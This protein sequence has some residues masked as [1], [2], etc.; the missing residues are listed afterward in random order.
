MALHKVPDNNDIKPSSERNFGFIFC[1]FF[2]IVALWPLT[3]GDKVRWWA[4]IIAALF[5]ATGFA[6]PALLRPLNILWFRFGLLLHAIFSPLILGLIFLAVVV[7]TGL[8]LRLLGKDILDL[9]EKPRGERSS[10]WI[11][12][13][14]VASYA[15]SMRNQF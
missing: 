1:C 4:L 6:L 12:R 7:P 2:L 8:L 3:L 15:E 14:A 13:S 9:N 11:R 5:G 10:Y